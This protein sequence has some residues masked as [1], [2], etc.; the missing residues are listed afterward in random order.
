MLDVAAPR[1]PADR[2]RDGADRRRRLRRRAGSR[3]PSA[4]LALARA[5][6]A[7]LLGAVGGPQ[8]DTLPR[9][10]RPEQGILGIRKELGLFANLRPAL[11]YPELA[12][13]VD[14]EARGR[15]RP[16]HHHRPRADRRHLFRRSRAAA[17][18]T[19]PARTKASTRCS[20]ACPRS[21]ASRASASR[22]RAS[23][24]S[25]LCSV[26]KA[27]VLDTS[28]LWREVVTAMARGLSRRRAVA[29]V[30]RQRG[31]AA[32]AQS[33]AV[34]R[35]RHRQPLR[36]HPVRRGVDARRL[37]RHAAFGVARRARARGSTSRSTAPRPT[38][39]GRTRPIRWRR[40]CRV[41]MMF[42]YTFARAD[43]ADRIEARRAR[44]AA[45]RP[46]HRR[47]RA[48]RRAGD[49]HPRDGRR[50]RCCV[51]TAARESCYDSVLC[52]ILPPRLQWHSRCA[53]SLRASARA[54][55]RR[56]SARPKSRRSRRPDRS[57]RPAVASAS[58][59]GAGR[60]AAAADFRVN[61]MR[62]GFV[63]WRG[64]VGSVLLQRMQAER[65]FDHIDPLFFSTS[66][67]GGKGPAIG[68]RH[69]GAAR[70]ERPRGARRRR[71]RSSPA[72]AATTPTTC[73]RSCAPP[74][75]TAT[76]STPRRR[77]G[78]PTTP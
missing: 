48:C 37:D 62:V 57:P 75:G 53:P 50:R 55:P 77:C 25:K 69:A 7:V 35:D 29:H 23:A 40:S 9:A 3:C 28:I 4:T 68:K 30:R 66:N 72:R 45:A 58:G 8:Y 33:E 41:A 27:N 14:A 6:D 54:R 46:A 21:R 61:A 70:R 17:A 59:P 65:D 39:P 51:A 43:V 49:R 26:D 47:H 63:G 38:S 11:A 12:G 16:R 52:A 5:A 74:A 2:D 36:R 32:R 78:W 18:T 24:A 67:V 34:R 31:D 64:M 56:T 1:R 13:G 73:S 71:T 22:P 76:G 44:G 20:T 10:M 19:P 60:I 42:R 15:R